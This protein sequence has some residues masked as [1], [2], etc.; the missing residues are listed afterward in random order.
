MLNVW[1]DAL[2]KI[3]RDDG[4]LLCWARAVQGGHVGG[5]IVRRIDDRAGVSSVVHISRVD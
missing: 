1:N 3:L 5:F 2:W 4:L